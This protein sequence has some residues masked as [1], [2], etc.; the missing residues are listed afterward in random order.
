[1]IEVNELTKRYGRRTAVDGLTFAVGQGEIVGFLG[2]NGA[3]KSTTMR[4]L[5]GYLAPSK[6]KVRVAGVDV[7]LEP[8]LAKQKIGYMPEAVPLYPEMR[9]VEYLGFRAEAKGLP[10]G[11]R[12]SRIGE[13]MEKARIGEVANVVCGALSKGYKQRVGLADAL[14]GAPPVLLLDEPTAGLDPNQVREVRSLLTELARVHTVLLSTHILSEVDATCS[15]A[16]IVHKG[17]LHA[18][19]TLA[20]IR[21]AHAPTFVELTVRGPEAAVKKAAASLSATVTVRHDT[22][23]L[24]VPLPETERT[25]GKPN[26]EAMDRLAE[27]AARSAVEGGLELRELRRGAFGLEEVFA[28]LTR[29]ERLEEAEASS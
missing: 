15:R 23:V 9:V 27:R 8:R 24:T 4:I 18:E 10:R 6:G 7:E 22:R 2:P 16:V 5:A 19:G 3:G 11:I 26:E 13:C 14:L 25:P 21:A 29:S 17:R 12:R 20:E 28:E 1:M